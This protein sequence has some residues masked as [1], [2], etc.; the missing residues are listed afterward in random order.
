MSKLSN[1]EFLLIDQY[2]NAPNLDARIQ[3]HRR[4][5]TNKYGWLRW[6][7]DQFD[8]PPACRILDLGCKPTNLWQQQDPHHQKPWPISGDRSIDQPR[9]L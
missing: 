2:K 4:F 1:Q 3:L 7:F 9:R 5:S 6:V 8:L